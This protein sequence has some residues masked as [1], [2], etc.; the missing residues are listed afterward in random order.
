MGVCSYWYGGRREP[1]FYRNVREIVEKNEELVESVRVA[2]PV[3]PVSFPPEIYTEDDEF[4]ATVRFKAETSEELKKLL[5]LREKLYLWVVDATQK[6]RR[7]LLL[8]ID[9]GNVGEILK[10]L[11]TQIT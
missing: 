8:M 3:P 9:E 6:N 4:Y 7:Y 1:E 5:R 2:G 10:A 11:E